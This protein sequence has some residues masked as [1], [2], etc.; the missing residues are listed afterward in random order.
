MS[1]IVEDGPTAAQL[2]TP[3]WRVLWDLADAGA[4]VR[5]R[6]PPAVRRVRRDGID[7][8]ALAGVG[9]VLGA[10]VA[11]GRPELAAAGLWLTASEQPE[12]G[13]RV[14]AGARRPGPDG[15]DGF[16]AFAVV[17]AAA[18]P[19]G[20]G[21]EAV[22][23]PAPALTALAGSRLSAPGRIRELVETIDDLAGCVAWAYA[24]RLRRRTPGAV[25]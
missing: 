4:P 8:W 1:R 13:L 15:Q 19:D 10:A 14:V 25:V 21:G 9:A 16:E 6:F 5:G 18:D 23:R 17:D 11:S 24:D 20:R 12:G 7:G 22:C 3:A 2:A